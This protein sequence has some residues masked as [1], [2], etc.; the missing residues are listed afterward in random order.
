MGGGLRAPHMR[1]EMDAKCPLR[2]TQL[3][4]DILE[5]PTKLLER[6]GSDNTRP[7][8]L[9]DHPD[10][11]GTEAAGSRAQRTATR[12]VYEDLVGKA[13]HNRVAYHPQQ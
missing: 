4:L 1:T 2:F 12:L 3:V 13:M 10:P 11:P 9:L 8:P 5:L 7:R 6:N